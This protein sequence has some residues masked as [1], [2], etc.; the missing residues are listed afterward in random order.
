[1]VRI[2]A[3]EREV[4]ADGLT[5]G[6]WI[7][8]VDLDGS[9]RPGLL[10][11]G[12]AQG[13][14]RWF[15][16]PGWNEHVIAELTQP[17]AFDAADLTGDGL[18][19]LV[20]CH[21]YGE[22]MYAHKP[23]DGLISWLRNP[24][25]PDGTWERRRIGQ[26]V[27][28]HRLRF[29]HYTK[30]EG[31]QLLALPVVGGAGGRAGME[32]P[33]SITVYEPPEDLLGAEEWPVAAVDAGSFGILHDYTRFGADPQGRERLLVASREGLNT[34]GWDPSSQDWSTSGIGEGEHGQ[35]ELT[36]FAGS[37][38][39][40]AGALPSQGVRYAAAL[41]PFHG[42]TVAVYTETEPGPWARTVLDVFGDP[43]EVGEGPGHHVVAADFDGDGDDEFLVALRGPMPWQG[44]FYYKAIDARA[45]LWVKRRVS[46]D[47]AARIAVADFNG[48]GRPDF[49]TIGYAVPGY[50]LADDPSVA[51][52]HNLG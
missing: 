28:A 6:Y 26:L 40:A 2:P 35:K 10:T 27:S 46:A 17:V 38:S 34:Y 16:N 36:G 8:A 25:T 9:G 19:D 51:V 32:Q 30:P 1:M 49:A 43:N 22:S 47:S 18:P 31:L 50:F 39:V 45:G 44:V 48:D 42:N 21:E 11:S 13:I 5:D 7:Q 33:A 52:F 14:V 12:L 24:G 15:A 20:V 4:I 29:G 41:E 23:D 37:S 3:F